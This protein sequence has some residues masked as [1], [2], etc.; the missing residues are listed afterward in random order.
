MESLQDSVVFS[1]ASRVINLMCMSAIE[2]RFSSSF[3]PFPTAKILRIGVMT[4][5]MCS[6]QI[7]LMPQRLDNQLPRTK[8]SK[9]L[10]HKLLDVGPY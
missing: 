3:K 10:D 1:A 9:N 4:P 5:G 6:S 7:L 8:I 2:S